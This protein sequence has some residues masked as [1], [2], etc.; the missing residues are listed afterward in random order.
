M[1]KL[2]LH[3]SYCDR[4]SARR[5]IDLA[6]PAEAADL[7]A[8]YAAL[9]EEFPPSPADGDAAASLERL[10]EAVRAIASTWANHQSAIVASAIGTSAASSKPTVRLGR[11]RRKTATSLQ[12]TMR[13]PSSSPIL[14]F[15]FPSPFS[16]DSGNGYILGCLADESGGP[17]DSDIPAAD[18]RQILLD[19]DSETSSGVGFGCESECAIKGQLYLW[20]GDADL[21]LHFG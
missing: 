21:D 12:Q 17:A 5:W 2:G 19:S 3:R 10:V 4:R 20:A 11:R 16:I 15:P 18:A 8:G 1:L 14:G 13:L 6:D 9:L 7:A